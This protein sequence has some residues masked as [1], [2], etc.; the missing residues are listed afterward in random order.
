MLL[1]TIVSSW[2]SISLRFGVPPP[3]MNIHIFLI[4][5]KQTLLREE[6]SAGVSLG[7]KH[8]NVRGIVLVE[9]LGS[10]MSSSLAPL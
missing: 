10:H 7:D 4:K 6:G 9:T 8:E 3:R 5:W 1:I 2:T